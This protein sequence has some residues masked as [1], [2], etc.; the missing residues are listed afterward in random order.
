MSSVQDSDGL[1]I[2]YDD[3][4]F[5]VDTVDELHLFAARAVLDG[6]KMWCKLYNITE[7]HHQW[8]LRNGLSGVKEFFPRMARSI[9]FLLSTPDY[10][11]L[12]DMRRVS[13][14][15]RKN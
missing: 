3:N 1:K 6:R 14:R 13:K 15:S 5:E 7:D 9:E 11:H 12:S 2:I 8:F 10:E 4:E